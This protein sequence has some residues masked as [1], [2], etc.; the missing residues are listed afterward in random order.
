[1]IKDQVWIRWET[2]INW[3]GQSKNM[4][5][6]ASQTMEYTGVTSSVGGPVV[7]CLLLKTRRVI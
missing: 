3:G 2:V 1:M 4:A 5:F 7:I 6:V